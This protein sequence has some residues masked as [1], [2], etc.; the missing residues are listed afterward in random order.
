[1][2]NPASTDEFI[3]VGKLGRPRG[4]NGELHVTLATDFPERFIGLT[5]IFVRDKGGWEKRGLVSSRMV[6]GQPVLGFE[7][8]T[9]PEEAARLTNREL[10]VPRNLAVALPE[11]TYYIFDLI[12]CDVF[13]E[14]SGEQI[15]QV[16]DV[17]RYPANDLYV[18]RAADGRQWLCPVVRH[19]VKSVD[20]KGRKIVV[21]RAG[22]LED[23]SA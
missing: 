23:Q 22:L 9:S 19:V 20:I 14:S 4:V 7:N 21:D 8:V 11:G 13:D 17:E 16:A 3:V 1:M 12:G 5:E 15:G 18:V 6:G 10:A 2:N